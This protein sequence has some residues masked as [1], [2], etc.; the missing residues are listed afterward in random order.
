MSSFSADPLGYYAILGLSLTAGDEEI[1]R[2]YREQAKRWHPDHNTDPA[3]VETFQKISVAYDVIS[4][5]KQRLIYDL[6]ARIY[7]AAKFPDMKALKV[8]TNRKGQ[9][10][11]NLR[12]VTLRQVIGKLT[13]F[14]DTS[15]AEICN[16]NEAKSLVLRNS[17][18]N[19]TLGWWNIPGLAYNLHA[20]AANYK[21]IGTNRQE[22]LTL[23]VHNML[24]Y[25]QENKLQQAYLSGQLALDYA[26]AEEA[27]LINRFLSTLPPV[28]SPKPAAWNFRQLKNLQLLIPGILLFVLLMGVSTRV[29]NWREFNKYFAR[30]N[31]VTYYQEVHFNSGRGVDDVVVSKVVDIPVDTED[32]RRLYHVIEP[33]AVMYGPDDN[34]DKLVEIRGQTTVRL[35][36]YTPNKVWARIMVDNGET[37]FV[38]LSKLKKALAAQFLMIVKSIPELGRRILLTLVQF[39]PVIVWIELPLMLGTSDVS[40]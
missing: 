24:A 8:Y 11:V 35:T 10:E 12:T 17:L 29:M 23:L 19:W 4:D 40:S 25:A 20:I 38:R 37:G 34:F 39:S 22:N 36:G 2:S 30:N 32:Q 1:K 21:N 27:G 9:Q 14:T 28:Q 7:P 26:Q 13:A 5:S 6:L 3:A 33:V 15:P 16:F 31:D 18:I